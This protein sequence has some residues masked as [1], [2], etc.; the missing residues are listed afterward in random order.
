MIV[1][2]TGEIGPVI[3]YG[4]M[5]AFALVFVFSHNY[6]RGPLSKSDGWNLIYSLKEKP[7]KL[8]LIASSVFSSF[9]GRKPNDD[10]IKNAQHYLDFMVDEGLVEK[11]GED[12]HLTIRSLEFIEWY[13]KKM[14]ASKI[15]SIFWKLSGKDYGKY[16]AL[17]WAVIVGVALVTLWLIQ[18]WIVGMCKI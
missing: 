9:P 17:V 13:D 5:G 18:C 1:G 10:D 11:S 15:V 6:S 8:D 16:N 2:V 4:L 12:Y 14:S 3:F 7:Q